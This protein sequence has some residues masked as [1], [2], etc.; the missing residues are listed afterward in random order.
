MTAPQKK[1]RLGVAGLGRAFTLMLPTLVG[2]ERIVLAAG[3]DPRPEARAQFERDF[4]GRGYESVE[5][6]CGAP[7]LDA[8]YVSTPHKVVTP[9]GK[10]RYSIAFFLDP[11]PDAIVAIVPFMHRHVAEPGDWTSD[12]DTGSRAGDIREHPGV[13]WQAPSSLAG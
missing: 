6:M 9:P 10:D 5:A 4:G 8:I 1:I 12:A 2:D 13:A 3:A 7:D 11:D